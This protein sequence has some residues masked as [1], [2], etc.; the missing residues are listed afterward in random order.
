MNEPRKKSP[1]FRIAILIVVVV[2][3]VIATLFYNAISEK[4]EYE[5]D[6]PPEAASAPAGNSA[7]G[8]GG[9]SQ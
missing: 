4:R 8:A 7:N 1:T 5:R 3:M 6:N 9:A 2:L